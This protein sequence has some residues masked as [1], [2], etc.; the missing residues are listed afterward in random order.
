M[1]SIFGIILTKQKTSNF[2]FRQ[3]DS[4]DDSGSFL[5]TYTENEIVKKNPFSSTDQT[6]VGQL[7]KIACEG[8]IRPPQHKEEA[9]FHHLRY[10]EHGGDPDFDKFCQKVGLTYVSCSPYRPAQ[11]G[12]PA[13]PPPM[14]GSRK[15]APLP[16]RSNSSDVGASLLAIPFP[17]PAPF[18]A[19]GFLRVKIALV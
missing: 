15:S 3:S 14:P 1:Y 17:S 16:R 4:R 11:P 5:S 18:P 8:A 2:D 10:G 19:R 13:L 6:G 9:R 7:V 12:S